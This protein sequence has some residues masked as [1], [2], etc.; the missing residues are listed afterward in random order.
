MRKNP[1]RSLRGRVKQ[2][3][4]KDQPIS[5]KPSVPCGKLNSTAAKKSIL[6][7]CSSGASSNG[8]ILRIS[9]AEAIRRVNECFPDDSSTKYNSPPRNEGVPKANKVIPS[10]ANEALNFGAGFVA[11]HLANCFFASCSSDELIFLQIVANC[12]PKSAVYLAARHQ[13]RCQRPLRALLEALNEFGKSYTTRS[14]EPPHTSG[15]R[16]SSKNQGKV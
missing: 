8:S 2:R 3:S 6:N 15:S 1:S 10:L 4:S 16:P 14:T 7:L 11:S 13:W 12:G 5:N 9:F